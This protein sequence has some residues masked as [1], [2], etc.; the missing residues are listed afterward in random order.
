MSVRTY[1]PLSFHCRSFQICSASH[2]TLESI[3]LAH[4]LQIIVDSQLRKCELNRSVTHVSRLRLRLNVIIRL[5]EKYV[6]CFK[7]FLHTFASN[8]FCKFRHDSVF[9]FNSARSWAMSFSS[10]EM[11]SFSFLSF[12]CKPKKLKEHNQQVQ[13]ALTKYPQSAKNTFI[14]LTLVSSLLHTVYE[15]NDTVWWT[16]IL[17]FCNFRRTTKRLQLSLFFLN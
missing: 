12:S 5:W 9:C 3:S 15:F 7:F 13:R 16:K 2:L 11:W 14:E 17:F 1:G 10:D 8:V 4:F 6:W